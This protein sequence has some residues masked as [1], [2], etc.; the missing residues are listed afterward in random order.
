MTWP[1]IPL[2]PMRG[3]RRE[4]RKEEGEEKEGWMRPEMSCVWYVCGEGGREGGREGR[5]RKRCRGRLEKQMTICTLYP[6]Q[7]LSLPPS[8]PPSLV[9]VP[10]T[11]TTSLIWAL[12]A[13]GTFS[14]A[15]KQSRYYSRERRVLSGEVIWGLAPLKILGLFKHPFSKTS[16]VL[17][18]KHG[19]QSSAAVCKS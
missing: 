19:Q 12:Q 14:S 13:P 4:G 5:M 10:S 9:S 15:Q 8:L 7:P 1:V 18:R 2:L 11:R 3:M 6:R 17:E 16:L